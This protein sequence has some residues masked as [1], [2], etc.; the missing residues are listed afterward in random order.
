M[1]ETSRGIGLKA[2]NGGALLPGLLGFS[3]TVL[4]SLWGRCDHWALSVLRR[5]TGI[6]T[7]S[8][9][10]SRTLYDALGGLV[11]CVAGFG[12]WRRGWL[13]FG[14]KGGVQGFG[15][16]KFITRRVL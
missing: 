15:D 14:L 4:S 12:P 1:V 8:M 2:A 16:M 6:R 10:L 9:F 3:G 5:Q 13:S 7:C 11:A